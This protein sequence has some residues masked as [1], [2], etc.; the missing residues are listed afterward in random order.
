MDTTVAGLEADQATAQL[1]SGVERV[2]HATDLNFVRRMGWLILSSSLLA[3]GTGIWF[4]LDDLAIGIAI[5]V[6]GAFSLVGSRWLLRAAFQRMTTAL[7]VRRDGLTVLHHGAI[8]REIPWVEM[9]GIKKSEDKDQG[10]QWEIQVR[11]GNHLQIRPDF[12][13]FDAL[14][15]R[16][17]SAAHSNAAA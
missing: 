16:L 7:V 1:M 3:I 5:A 6:G 17:Q 4:A 8:G 14:L 12:D 9:R 2:H 15:D 11:N 13:D 10:T